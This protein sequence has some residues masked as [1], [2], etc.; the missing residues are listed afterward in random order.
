MG[1]IRRGL[2][3]DTT[4]DN[5]NAQTAANRE[6]QRAAAAAG[7]AAVQ[8]ATATKEIILARKKAGEAAGKAL[9]D[10]TVA[11]PTIDLNTA[12]DLQN[13]VGQK[14]KRRAQFGFD[15]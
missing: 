12:D 11:A 8:A 14:Q 5:A 9:T 2:G 1:A 13:S 4:N 15:L 10:G 3:I 6:A 7:N